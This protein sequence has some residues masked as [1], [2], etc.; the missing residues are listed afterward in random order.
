MV[1]SL[2][3]FPASRAAIWA[4]DTGTSIA[5]RSEEQL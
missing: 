5:K 2:L 1:S 3:S 4:Y